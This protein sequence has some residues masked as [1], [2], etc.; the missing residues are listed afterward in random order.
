MCRCHVGY[1][2]L[3]WTLRDVTEAD[4]GF[5]AIAGSHKVYTYVYTDLPCVWTYRGRSLEKD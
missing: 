1:I 4:G 5:C 3:G 2:N